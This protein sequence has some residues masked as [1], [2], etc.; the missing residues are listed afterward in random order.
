MNPYNTIDD[1]FEAYFIYAVTRFDI[2][3]HRNYRHN[4]Y[5]FLSPAIGTIPICEYTKDNFHELLAN[6]KSVHKE[7]R[8]Y[9]LTALLTKMFDYA[10]QKQLIYQNPCFATSYRH[11]KEYF[12]N[13]VFSEEEMIRIVQSLSKI[14]DESVENFIGILICTGLRSSEL[15]A[16]STDKI[17]GGGTRLRIDQHVSLHTSRGKFRI[18]T[19]MAGYGAPRTI[20]LPDPAAACLA[21]QLAIVDRWKENG[22][23]SPYHLIFDD[24]KRRF[25]TVGYL[26]KQYKIIRELASVS[27]FN[28]ILIRQNYCFSALKRK[29]N[30]K[31]LQEYTGFVQPHQLMTMFYGGV[32]PVQQDIA[33]VTGEY[34]AHAYQAATRPSNPHSLS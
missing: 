10:V 8:V 21:K 30:Q 12:T 11:W 22:W 18:K 32:E 6:M 16:V 26:P 34:Y 24:P 15:M 17:L 31:S 7:Y 3:T 20:I 29:L 14:G 13:K 9:R 5:N 33:E 19:D 4:Y 28:L 23:A 27:D 25:L 1:L 2:A